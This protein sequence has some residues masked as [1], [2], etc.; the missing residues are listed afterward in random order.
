MRLPDWKRKSMV[1]QEAVETQR[2]TVSANQ[3]ENFLRLIGQY[4][5]A[6]RRLAGAYLE[7][8]ADREDLFQDI[9]VALWQSI[10]KFRGESSE[11]TWL[12]RI[13]HN[14]AISSA[15]KIRRVGRKEESIPM[16]FDRFSSSPGAEQALLKEERRLLLVDSIRDLPMI[17]RQIILLH[18]ESLSYA[19]IE[20]VTGLSESA[21]A[22]RLT[23]IREKLK[24]NIRSKEV[25]GQ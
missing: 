2:M 5:P 3:R 24:E 8:P 9:A 11:R 14:V 21:I 7:R 12:Y 6:L 17:D 15:A 13:A 16:P 4:E 22:T 18:L 19:E 25:G 20:D 10:A 1:D 23:R